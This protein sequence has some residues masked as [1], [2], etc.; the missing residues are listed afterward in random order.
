MALPMI[1]QN[2]KQIGFNWADE[3]GRTWLGGRWILRN[4][5]GRRLPAT[6]S[7]LMFDN[8]GVNKDAVGQPGPSVAVAGHHEA[9]RPGLSANAPRLSKVPATR[10]GRTPRSS[11]RSKDSSWNG[12]RPPTRSCIAPTN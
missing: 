11:P 6:L 2:D 1:I 5:S 10:Y 7:M 3:T 12:S 8:S 9:L 4:E